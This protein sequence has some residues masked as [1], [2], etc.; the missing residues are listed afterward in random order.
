ME[1]AYVYDLGI[2]QVFPN[3]ANMGEWSA[4]QK[5]NA[6]NEIEKVTASGD[7]KSVTEKLTKLA[8]LLNAD[9]AHNKPGAP[10]LA[11]TEF[12]PAG[13]AGMDFTGISAPNMG[14]AN[15]ETGGGAAPG[16]GN[17]G[18]GGG[19][20]P[21]MGNFGAGGGTAPGMGNFGAGGGTAPGMGNFGAGGGTAPGMGNFGPGGAGAP[22]MGNFKIGGA[23]APSLPGFKMADGVPGLSGLPGF[24]SGGAP[25]LPGLPGMG[26]FGAG[27][28][29]AP[30]MGKF[31]AGGAGAPG[32]GN[33]GAG[34]AGA[35]GMGNF[36]AGGA[37]APGMGNFKIGG[38]GAPS[39]PGFKMADG[40]PGLS[41]LPGFPSGGAPALPG[42]PG[43]GQFGAGGSGAP[44]M[45]KFGAGGAGAPGMS[46]FGAGGAGAPGMGQ[47]GAGG[48]GAPGMGS[49][50]LGGGGAPGLSGFKMAGGVPGLSGMP[51]MSGFGGAEGGSS[52]GSGMSL[53]SFK[54][55]GGVGGLDSVGTPAER[56]ALIQKAEK[57]RDNKA[58]LRDTIAGACANMT[59]PDS[60]A[61]EQVLTCLH[62]NA[63]ESAECTKLCQKATML[64]TLEITKE[65]SHMNTS[66]EN[67]KALGT[68]LL[69]VAQE[70][71]AA[72]V[73]NIQWPVLSDKL[74]AMDTSEFEDYD[75]DIESNQSGV[76]FSNDPAGQHLLNAH[77]AS[78]AKIAAEVA[79][80]AL[81]TQQLAVQTLGQ[82]LT[83]ESL[84]YTTPL[85]QP[86]SSAIWTVKTSCL[87][88]RFKC[89]GQRRPSQSL[90]ATCSV[91]VSVSTA[92]PSCLAMTTKLDINTYVDSGINLGPGTQFLNVDMMDGFG[93]PIEVKDTPEP[94]KI[95]IERTPKYPKMSF[96]ETHLKIAD[97]NEL[98]YTQLNVTRA[99][100]SVHLEVKEMKEK[101]LQIMVILKKGG[102]PKISSD[103][104]DG[105]GFIPKSLDFTK[106]VKGR[107]RFFMD[108][109][110]INSYIGPVWFGFRP[111]PK[112]FDSSK[113]ESCADLDKV[114]VSSDKNYT[115]MNIG[116]YTFTSGCYFFDHDLKD[117]AS[118][119]CT[120]GEGTNYTQ[121]D[122]Y[123]NHL[124]TFGSG[125]TVAPHTID[126]NF[127]FSNADFFKNPTIYVTEIAIAIFYVL[128]I[129]WARRKD[130]KD[131]E[132]L[133]VTPLKDNDPG[134]KYFYE[135]VVVTGNCKNAGTDSKVFIVLSG[136]NDETDVRM[137]NDDSRKV[138]T[139]GGVD[140]FLMA[141]EGPLGSL[142][143][144]RVWHD[145]SGRGKFASWNL[146]YLIVR[147]VQTEQ[148]FTFLCNRW[149]A[150]EEDDGQVDR[151]VPVAGPA[152]LEEF[153]QVFSE[154][155]MKDLADGH[156]WFSVVTRPPQSRF[157]RVQR[158]S[159]CLCL[160][161]ATMLVNAMFYEKHESKAG[162]DYK[163]GPFVLSPKQVYVGLIANLVVFPINFAIIMLFRKSRA[164][165]LRPSRVEEALRNI[166][167]WSSTSLSDVNAE[168]GRE[169]QKGVKLSQV[170]PSRP[171]S[172]CS[173]LSDR[174]P[175]SMS[176]GSPGRKKMELPWF[177]R[178]LAWILLWA[179]I[180]V[181]AAMVTFYGISFRDEK[182]RKWVTSMLVSF[183]TSIFITEPIKVFLTVLFFSMI[184]KKPVDDEDH[185]PE[186][187]EGSRMAYDEELLHNQVYA[188]GAAR[189][190]KI[191]Y[192]PP[193]PTVLQRARRQRLNEIKMWDIIREIVFYSFF[194][195]I[196]MV[197]SY[198]NRS[199]DSFYYKDSLEKMIIK[200]ND[201]QQWFSEI[202]N[203]EE[204]WL[205]A[206][207]AL[208]S[209]LRA[210]NY[211]NN[212]PALLLRGFIGDKVSRIM[213]Y[214]TMRQLRVKTGQCST[215][216][217][218][219]SA[220]VQCNEDYSMLNEDK[221]SYGTRWSPYD[222]TT[223]ARK[224]Y[225]YTPAS[226]LNG[227]PYWGLLGVYGG[228]GYVVELRGSK[229]KLDK[230]MTSLKEENWIDKYTRAVF[231]EFTVYN[232]QV[233]LF[234]IC[235]IVAEFPSSGG[236]LASY[237]FEP[238][239]LLPYITSVMYFQVVC[240]AIYLCFTIAFII[241]EVR[242]FTKQGSKYFRSFW[243]WIELSIITMSIAAIVVYFYRLFVTITLTSMFKKNKGNEY[244]KFQYVGYWNELFSYMVGWL[245]FF[246]SL[247]FLKL[248]RFNKRMSLLGSTLESCA[249]SILHFS[250]MFWVVFLAFMQLFYQTFM[251]TSL[252]FS[253]F[254]KAA[255][256]GILMMMGKIDINEMLMVEPIL[257]KV[258][259]FFFV[260]TVTFIL[261]NMFLSILNDTFGTVR[262]DIKKKNNDYEIVDFMDVE[263]FPN[264]IDRLLKSINNVYLHDN[265][266]AI[267]ESNGEPKKMA[268]NP[269]MKETRDGDF[270]GDGPTTV[271]T[272]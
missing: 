46:N 12:Q 110:K 139:R 97:W 197:V 113:V 1:A 62:T 222:L 15:F 102:L 221:K 124:T 99:E 261:V 146:K 180:F 34:G 16:M 269:Q 11:L 195:W 211:Y 38:A 65:L 14:L 203:T 94:L 241:K 88:W 179:V 204:F 136:D 230:A 116:I 250:L 52:L 177:C 272:N 75:T 242:N 191:G 160:L 58:K 237:R 121:T 69:N 43:M 40:V 105:V 193:D 108:N 233:N 66:S 205:W 48:A 47:F 89:R 29:G 117:W 223:L 159:C 234:A 32:M 238:A 207:S 158:V 119:G 175:S 171:G 37:G 138:L 82:T 83:R 219:S 263:E 42:L 266:E 187:E 6:L 255:E 76:A 98:Y 104:C 85:L 123:C 265:L 268:M 245:V 44:G 109:N 199:P 189:P 54:I 49:F 28:S 114:D 20:A 172:S 9:K 257:T 101:D 77:K 235:T 186:D 253:T 143:Y 192:K 33:F 45:G 59:T 78:Q 182:V 149:F 249:Q 194:V 248:L 73:V 188:Y 27:G 226:E 270:K 200:N 225:I 147:D 4:K 173:R 111:M 103:K 220:I 26:Q 206:R 155:G 3:T 209:S 51:D 162:T 22:G 144:A 152:E 251:S 56:K 153:G 240:E 57:E 150:V 232:P 198:R 217:V 161:A 18:A 35:P 122:C 258:Y 170:Q 39:L 74:T 218:M 184:C 254:I 100:S 118:Q 224:E 132:A 214:A 129:V 24:P 262:V 70:A 61:M 5:T 10:G 165:R 228:G 2:I 246:G 80:M 64:K 91:T 178:Y 212:D 213:G 50:Q 130:R 202:Q 95:T 229:E 183:V 185:R 243:N 236:V 55:A 164:R 79:E 239:M 86:E 72:A 8:S 87:V 201:T 60:T 256:S 169:F 126:W 174:S 23:G 190:K 128:A 260:V 96:N 166:P 181:S 133:G 231:V 271:H 71:A 31:G 41:G 140:S 156:I 115:R 112:G 107:M 259:V 120:V 227:Y 25:G 163:F 131:V 148:K 135:V 167:S 67:T 215:I 90:K 168:V 63:K 84:E 7:Q 17:F 21:G 210:D 68:A 127:V 252:S 13:H 106:K 141:V 267:I 134:D 92:A 196:L 208:V 157:T 216:N 125:W 176:Q 53:N 145:N 81:Q 93:F 151:V 30:G 36:G 137:L 244:M 247:K 142:N 264:R 154:K 19:A